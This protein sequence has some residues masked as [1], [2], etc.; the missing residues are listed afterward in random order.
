MKKFL[1]SAAVLLSASVSQAQMMGAAGN[2][3]GSA[4]AASPAMEWY[5]CAGTFTVASA[6]AKYAFTGL[7]LRK[8]D[9]ESFEIKGT[10][11][12][13]KLSAVLL[14]IRTLNPDQILRAGMTYVSEGNLEAGETFNLSLLTSAP[15]QPLLSSANEG[16]TLKIGSVR[17]S[18]VKGEL[19][20]QMINATGSTQPFTAQFD[21][22]DSRYG[23]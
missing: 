4:E 2:S 22:I 10:S 15:V 16:C 11:S 19:T 7:Q 17:G 12:D 9:G 3:P 23:R 5:P 21:V 8:I 18:T 6:D 1:L 14:H 20:G 13:P